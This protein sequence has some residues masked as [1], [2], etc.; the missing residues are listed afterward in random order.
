[1]NLYATCSNYEFLLKCKDIRP[2]FYEYG[3]N[4]NEY[5]S[6][7]LIFAFDDAVCDTDSFVDWNIESV[8]RSLRIVFNDH[9]QH[10]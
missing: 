9:S 7:T 10:R 4:V 5:S 6:G 1:M 2:I 8:I 3:I